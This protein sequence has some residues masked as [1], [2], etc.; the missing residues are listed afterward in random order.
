MVKT[1]LNKL[2]YTASSAPTL[3]N[4]VTQSDFLTSLTA[5]LKDGREGGVVSALTEVRD[6]LV[7]PDNLRVVMGTDVNRLTDPL[8]PWTKFAP[9]PRLVG[10]VRHAV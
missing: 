1:L 4:M 8:E 2:L 3:T 7:S 6:K 10:S 9:K 5:K